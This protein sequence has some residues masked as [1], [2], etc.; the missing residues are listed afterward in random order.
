VDLTQLL[1]GVSQTSQ[2]RQEV[3]GEAARR[4]AA[5][6]LFTRPAAEATVE[7]I[8]ESQALR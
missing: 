3:I 2:V 4:L 8:L 1:N 5:G 6:E 7:G